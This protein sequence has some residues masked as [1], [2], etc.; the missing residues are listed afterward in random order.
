[1]F[2]KIKN[3]NPLRIKIYSYNILLKTYEGSKFIRIEPKDLLL[4]LDKIK[5]K[6]IILYKL[7]FSEHV[8]F[9]DAYHFEETL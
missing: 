1:M 6:N 8:Y 2:I 5:Y 9:L 3:K 4:F 7:F